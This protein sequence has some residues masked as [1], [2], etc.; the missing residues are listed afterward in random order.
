MKKFER[1][2]MRMAVAATALAVAMPAF[3]GGPDEEAYRA[4]G[5]EL[6]AT[7]CATCHG[8]DGKG[9]GPVAKDLKTSPKDLARIA[10][11]NEGKF[12]PNFV[13]EIVDGQRYFIAHGDR[14]MPIWG[15]VFAQGKGQYAGGMR[16]YA[17]RIY[18][19]S[20]QEPAMSHAR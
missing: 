19:Q 1:G 10:E 15:D 7:H 9:D 16:V 8:A 4:W 12:P 14:V 18:L 6:F 3:A 5:K 17:L 20:I 13:E 11:R 2:S